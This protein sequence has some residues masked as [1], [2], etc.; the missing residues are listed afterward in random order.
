MVKSQEDI[1]SL[2][3]GREFKPGKY[4]VLLDIDNKVE[5]EVMTGLALAKLF[6]L[7][8]YEAPKQ[9]TPSGGLHYIFFMLMRNKHQN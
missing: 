6:N 8:Q 5:G 1:I 3:I 2:L 7:D 4:A 9:T